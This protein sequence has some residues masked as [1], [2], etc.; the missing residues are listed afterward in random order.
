MLVLHVLPR[1]PHQFAVVVV[2]RVLIDDAASGAVQVHDLVVR[3]V[4]S[5][6]IRRQ[7]GLV[8]FKCKKEQLFILRELQADMFG[9]IDDF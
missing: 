9:I 4:A 3:S 6:P 7:F 1:L 8:A 2:Q 5:L